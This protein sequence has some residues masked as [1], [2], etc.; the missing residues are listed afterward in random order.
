MDLGGVTEC[1]V[2]KNGENTRT[3]GQ[4]TSSLNIFHN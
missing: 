4:E 3:N 2:K 1:E